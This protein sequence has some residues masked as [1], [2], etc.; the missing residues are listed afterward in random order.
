MPRIPAFRRSGAIEMRGFSSAPPGVLT[1][2]RHSGITGEG[3]LVT[4]PAVPPT[5]ENEIV[6]PRRSPTFRVR[7]KTATDD[8]P[9]PG[10]PRPGVFGYP[11]R[12]L[13]AVAGAAHGG[14]ATGAELRPQVADVDVDDVRPWVKIEPPY[15]AQELLAAEHLLGM[16]QEFL[17]EAEFPCLEVDG[18]RPNCR[19]S[20]AG[21]EAEVTVNEQRALRRTGV[22]RSQSNSG[23]QLVE[24]EGLRHVIVGTAL[25][26]GDGI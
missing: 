15:P 24:S 19:S 9:A 2:S 25:E 8:P 10:T 7:R 20:G 16:P 11:A 13:P 4:A 6:L 12:S 23:K 26:P 3:N 21:I 5:K 1:R 14:D 22:L 17:G 18:A